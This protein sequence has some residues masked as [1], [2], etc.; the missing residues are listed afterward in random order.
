MNMRYLLIVTVMPVMLA[1]SSQAGLYNFAT[2]D[3]LTYTGGA[4]ELGQTIPDNTMAGVGY[5]INFDTD[6]VNIGSISVA[7]NI[8]GGY[9]GDLGA[10][11][12]HAGVL[13][14]LLNPNESVSGSG[15]NITLNE[16]GSPIPTGGSGTLTGSYVAFGDLSQFNSQSAAGDWTLFF[17]D[18]GAG[19]QSTING[20]ELSL[21]AVPEPVN[22]ALGVFGGIM[23]LAIVGRRFWE[24]K[25][26]NSVKG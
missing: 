1:A 7:L 25:R 18:Q 12:S 11:V 2:T 3:G 16:T 15:M 14:W 17:V 9:N 23:V 19:D 13:V 6:G 4:S 8:S 5:S 10:Y 26:A 21:T 24:T 22:A 20:F